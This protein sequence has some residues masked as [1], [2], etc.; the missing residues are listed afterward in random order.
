MNPAEFSA[1]LEEDWGWGKPSQDVSDLP[2]RTHF[3]TSTALRRYMDD[4]LE[5]PVVSQLYG[6]FK[7]QFTGSRFRAEFDCRTKAV[8]WSTV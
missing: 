3:V 2:K 5:D 4:V 8:T 1:M 7:I 6:P